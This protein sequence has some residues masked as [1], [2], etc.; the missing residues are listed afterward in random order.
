VLFLCTD[1]SARSIIAECVLDR[2]G[3]GRF[4]AY[5]AGSFPRDFVHPLALELLRRGGYDTA[6]LRSKSWNEFATPD[7]PRL[8]FVFTVCDDAA[9]EICPSWPGKPVTAHWGLPNP[10]T[11][12]GSEARRAF[13]FAVT[14]Q[15]LTERIEA[16]VDLPIDSLDRAALRARLQRIAVR[17][18]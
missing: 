3:E 6:K 5:S 16:L 12:I 14:L 8:D 4:K 1:N 18:Q 17:R 11:V 7:A 13:A 10:A 2:L 9:G 15:L